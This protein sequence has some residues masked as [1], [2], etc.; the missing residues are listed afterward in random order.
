[1]IKTFNRFKELCQV[2]RRRRETGITGISNEKEFVQEDHCVGKHTK[3]RE[4][5]RERDRESE[6]K[7]ERVD[8]FAT[9][10]PG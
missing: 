3:E 2:I 6:R 7:K 4:R 10:S 8:A 9:C 1:M 5:E